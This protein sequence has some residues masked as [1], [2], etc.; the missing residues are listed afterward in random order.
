MTNWRK[1]TQTEN[2][3]RLHMIKMRALFLERPELAKP[4]LAMRNLRMYKAFR[5]LYMYHV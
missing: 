4:L 5:K 1:V 3:M 2:K